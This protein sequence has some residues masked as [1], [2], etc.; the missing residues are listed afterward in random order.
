MGVSARDAGRAGPAKARIFISY[1]RRETAGYAGRLYDG[2]VDHF[3]P[4]RV[5][6]DVT[7]EPGVDF[8]ERIDEA[9]GSCAALIAL[10]GED[11]LRVTDRHGRRRI[12][13]PDD[14]HRLELEAALARRVLVIPTLVQDAN[15]PIPDELPEPLRPLLRRQ[16]VELSDERWDYDVGRLATVLEEALSGATDAEG[17][18]GLATRLRRRARR[19]R[20][21]ARRLTTRHPWRAGF[22]AGALTGVGAVAIVLA[23]TG[24]FNA[25]LL[26][27]TEFS[28]GAP[29][30]GTSRAHCQVNVESDYVVKEVY[31]TVDGDDVHTLDPQKDPPWNCGNQGRN[32]W[33]TCFTHADNSAQHV[34]PGRH[35]LTAVVTDKKDNVTRR[36]RIVETRCP[37]K[38]ARTGGAQGP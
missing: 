25:P 33:D 15:M 2:L 30:P 17:A 35:T 36:D 6:M 32:T 11:W 19:L 7:M 8:A 18:P 3:G 22:L 5:F 24:Q 27:V 28:Y 16:A 13:D 12:D 29:A 38:S 4:E 10:I 20:A 21:R 26:R 37:P 1:R 34:D 9:V 23:A 31:F 14:V